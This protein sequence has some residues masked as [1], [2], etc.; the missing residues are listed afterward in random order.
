MVVPG[1]NSVNGLLAGVATVWG[2]RRMAVSSFEV[3]LST[4]R[5]VQLTN[6]LGTWGTVRS[7][8]VS[9]IIRSIAARIHCQRATF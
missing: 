3:P 4:W 7:L 8:P 5:P 9:G 2:K 1:N 6:K